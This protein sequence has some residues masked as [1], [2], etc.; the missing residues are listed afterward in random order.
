M[1]TD[2]PRLEIAGCS[3][4]LEAARRAAES[5]GG[6]L[7]SD[8]REKWQHLPFRALVTATTDD[9]NLF[10]EFADVGVYLICRR[11]IKPGTPVSIGLF[12]M[13]RHPELTHQQSDAHWRDKHGP[14]AL[15][16]HAHMSHYS[17]LSVLQTLRGPEYDGFALCGF[18]S[19]DDLRNRFYTTQESVGIIAADVKKFANVKKSPAR[20][21][22]SI[23][24]YG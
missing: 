10:D 23:R 2:L 17:Q 18:N 9:L 19:E 7:Y 8:D 6:T 1:A 5:F 4:D 12:P 11:L 16:H 20:L 15:E 3:N 14:L 24:E 21:I 13:V 22:A